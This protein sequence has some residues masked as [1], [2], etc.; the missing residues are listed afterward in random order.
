MARRIKSHFRHVH[1]FS[2]EIVKREDNNAEVDMSLLKIDF[3][4]RLAMLS[5]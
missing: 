4:A 5:R 3:V 1:I 2:N